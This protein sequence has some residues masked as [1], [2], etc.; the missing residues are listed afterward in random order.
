MCLTA[1]PLLGQ[2]YP[3]PSAPP[4]PFLSYTGRFMDSSSTPD[5]Q[6]PART[7]RDNKVK[8][9]RAHDRMYVRAGGGYF[10]GYKLSTF[11]SRIGTPLST[12]FNGE[13]YLPFD[14]YVNPE[15]DPMWKIIGV[16]GQD[17]LMD[18]DFDSRGYIYLAYSVYGWGIVDLQ[19]HLQKQI[20]L[21]T[22]PT[23]VVILTFASDGH[24][25][26]ISSGY[27]AASVLYDVTDPTAP[28]RIGPMG[29]GIDAWAKNAAGDEIA[30]IQQNGGTRT[31][32]IYTPAALVSHGA[33][34]TIPVSQ[35]A[36]G[37]A[38][39]DVTGDGSNFYAAQ[40]GSPGTVIST[41]APSEGGY[42]ST[43][44]PIATG[45]HT[46]KLT[47]E[48]GYLALIGSTTSGQAG[49]MYR[50]NGTQFESYDIT[51]YLQANYA[52]AA[53]AQAQQMV[54]LCSGDNAFAFLQADGLGDVFALTPAVWTCLPG[55]PTNVTA[56]AGD[57][58]ATVSFSEADGGSPITAYSVKVADSGGYMIVPGTSS[59]ITVTGLVNGTT[60]TFTVTATNAIGTGAPSLASNEA[61]PGTTLAAP[62]HLAATATST[63][64]VSVTW[65]AAAFAAHYEVLR[66]SNGSSFAV[67]ASPTSPSYTDSGLTPSTT[68]LYM[69]RSVASGG[70]V[71]SNSSIDPATT[72]VFT[73]D[74]LVAGTSGKALHDDELRTA[75]NAMRAAAGLGAATFTDPTLSSTT[76]IRAVHINELRAALDTA[77]S[78]IGLTALSYTDTITAGVTPFKAVHV[79]EIR[80]GVK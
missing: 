6:Y 75:V 76:P 13:K 38:F 10:V 5:L 48:S 21:T 26:V 3:A 46:S 79:Q 71:S 28:V 25:Y 47:F 66:S 68:Y 55:A 73:D 9:D 17:R 57:S 22:D 12:F 34:T 74:P 70:A 31:L 32:Q 20:P 77:R 14:M 65:A 18:F 69:V 44:M 1:L 64:S 19:G 29:F 49:L 52:S 50:Y 63:S 45:T 60:Y 30:V 37:L 80:D 11:T 15:S 67:I 35:Q 7:L 61:T 62:V 41:I 4:S 8:F 40:D 27:T 54:A 56:A 43:D 39:T 2:N 23:P 58:S 51:S 36:A 53:H 72:I 42:S 16:D 33:G 78:T 59:P 24:Q